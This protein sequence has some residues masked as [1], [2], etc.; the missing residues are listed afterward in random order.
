M[1]REL[2]AAKAAGLQVLLSIRPGNPTQADAD[3][4]ERITSFD[5]V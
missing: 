5:I 3:V 1:T 4:F 2:D